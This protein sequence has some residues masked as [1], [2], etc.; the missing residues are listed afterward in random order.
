MGDSTSNYD[1]SSSFIRD[2]NVISIL[3][4]LFVMVILVFTFQ[5]AGLPVLLMMIIEGSIWINF[6]VPVLSGTNMFF[7]SYLIVSS[8]QMGANIDYAIVITNRYQEL[9]RKMPKQEAIIQ[10][11]NQVFPTIITSGCIL[12]AAGMF[13]GILSSEEAIS[14][15]GICL[16]RGTMMSIILVM[17]VLPQLLLL[18]DFIIEKTAFTINL[19]TAPTHTQQ[20]NMKIKGRVKGY[21]SGMIDGDFEGTLKG[22]INAVV[23]SNAVSCE[24]EEHQ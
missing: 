18:G 20:G 19:P 6:S 8:I 24:E 14:S 15:I 22:E 7:M 4:A 5:S 12:A 11:L 10:T 16:G 2:N 3:S 21:V 23:D 13:I 1:L 9:K 17:C